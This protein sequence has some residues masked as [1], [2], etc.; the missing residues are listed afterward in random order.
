MEVRGYNRRMLVSFLF[1]FSGKTTVA[2][3]TVLR[4]LKKVFVF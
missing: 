2:E 4:F 3:V 1:F